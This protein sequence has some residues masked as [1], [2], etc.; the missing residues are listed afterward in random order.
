MLPVLSVLNTAVCTITIFSISTAL[1]LALGHTHYCY[2]AFNLRTLKSS[3]HYIMN[4]KRACLFSCRLVLK[5]LL[6]SSHTKRLASS[7][8]LED[9]RLTIALIIVL[10]VSGNTRRSNSQCNNQIGKPFSVLI[11]S[12]GTS[13]TLDVF[14]GFHLSINYHMVLPD[15]AGTDRKKNNSLQS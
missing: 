9:P 5:V 2:C 8:D 7:T 10:D 13:L 4:A 14:A 3:S 11:E 1:H 15:L 6:Y 12:P